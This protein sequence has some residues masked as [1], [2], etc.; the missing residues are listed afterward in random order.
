M[1]EHINLLDHGEYYMHLYKNQLKQM[2]LK[3]LFNE[4]LGCNFFYER[5]KF[6]Q[7]CPG[8]CLF[9]QEFTFEVGHILHS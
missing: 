5:R 9:V 4:K 6:V 7:V 8:L 2:Q 3:N 1:H